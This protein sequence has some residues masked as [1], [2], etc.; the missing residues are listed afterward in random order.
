MATSFKQFRNIPHITLCNKT[1]LLKS[2]EHK[3]IL[4]KFMSKTR[5]GTGLLT[6][7]RQDNICWVPFP[8]VLCCLPALTLCGSS[9]QQ[10]K[11]DDAQIA[12]CK[13]LF[14]L[15]EAANN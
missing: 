15:Q 5:T 11:N 8:N 4:V 2:D 9:A 12:R 10:Y 13:E 6:W 14:A 1:C 7:P 3:N